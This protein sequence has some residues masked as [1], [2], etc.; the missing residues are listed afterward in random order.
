MVIEDKKSMVLYSP[1]EV[2][3][4]LTSRPQYCVPDEHGKGDWEAV[5]VEC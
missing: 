3:T 4:G 1:K 2:E 5:A